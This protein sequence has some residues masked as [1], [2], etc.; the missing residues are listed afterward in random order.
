MSAALLT[1]LMAI[2]RMHENKR[3][4]V[5]ANI[6]NHVSLACVT[7]VLFCDVIKMNFGLDPAIAYNITNNPL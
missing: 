6:L 1:V 4:E 3:Q 7:G 5:I 2:Y